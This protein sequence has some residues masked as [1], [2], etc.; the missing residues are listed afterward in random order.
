MLLQKQHL[1]QRIIPSLKYFLNA[2]SCSC[3]K[4]FLYVFYQMKTDAS[5]TI[6]LRKRKKSAGP[7]SG[8]WGGLDN[9]CWVVDRKFMFFS[10]WFIQPFCVKAKYITFRGYLFLNLLSLF[11]C[12][13]SIFVSTSFL[14]VCFWFTVS[15]L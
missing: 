14:I 12:F 1:R 6:E 8:E 5:W 10:K 7:I 11:Y 13:E 15:P 9:I 2:F 4:Y 3:H